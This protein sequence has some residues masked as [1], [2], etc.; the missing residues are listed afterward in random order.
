M[1]KFC[2]F[3]LHGFLS[4]G[5]SSKGQWFAN[6]VKQ[7]NYAEE[8]L[9]FVTWLTPSYPIATVSQTVKKIEDELLALLDDKS[10]EG[11]LILIGSSMGGFYVQYLGHKYHLP[12]I[13][14]NPALNPEAVFIDHMGEHTNPATGEKVLI[15]QSYID[16]LLKYKIDNPDASI[17][18]MM[19]LDVD[20]EVIDVNFALKQYPVDRAGNQ[21]NKTVIFSGGDHS[22]IHLEEAWKEIQ[23]FASQ[24]N[25]K[26]SH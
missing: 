21:S 16:E 3:Y 6:Q 19:L 15:N 17:A 8:E 12:Y 23:S 13:M 25:V 18:S 11:R 14:I 24:L 20:D 4:S 7:K 2:G 10:C 1:P 5:K 22:F 26:T 9:G